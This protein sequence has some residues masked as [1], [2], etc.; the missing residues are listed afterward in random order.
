M[1]TVD[2]TREK[3]AEN[4]VGSDED[5]ALKPFFKKES[6]TKERTLTL[7]CRQKSL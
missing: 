3:E 7:F 5:A 2:G 1:G 4:A 6:V